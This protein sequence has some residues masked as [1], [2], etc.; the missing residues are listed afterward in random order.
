MGRPELFAHIRTRNVGPSG[1]EI[2]T[3]KRKQEERGMGIYS[4]GN[5]VP[6]GLSDLPE[7]AEMEPGRRKAQASQA[8]ARWRLHMSPRR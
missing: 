1:T 5:K 3:P 4:W 7:Q 2:V 6:K 8:P